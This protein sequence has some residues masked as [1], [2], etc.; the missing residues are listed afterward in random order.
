MDKIGQLTAEVFDVFVGKAFRPAGAD[1]S[2]RLTT[3]DRREVPGWDAA[4]RKPFSLILRGPRSSVL[5]E[6]FYTVAIDEGPVLTLYVIP[7]LTASDDHQD[8]QIVFN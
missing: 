7:I 4:A 1:L 8:Y 2:L 5:P 3:I 6:G